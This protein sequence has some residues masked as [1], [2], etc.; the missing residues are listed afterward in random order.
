MTQLSARVLLVVKDKT[1][2]E[3]HYFDYDLSRKE[4]IHSVSTSVPGISVYS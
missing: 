1:K 4:A 3:A 2:L